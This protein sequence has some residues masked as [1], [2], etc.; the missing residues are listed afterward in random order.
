MLIMCTLSFFFCGKSYWFCPSKK[1]AFTLIEREGTRLS[2]LRTAVNESAGMQ[3][4]IECMTIHSLLTRTFSKNFL[5]FPNQTS[6]HYCLLLSEVCHFCTNVPLKQ[7]SL[8]GGHLV[9]F[10]CLHHRTIAM[11]TYIMCIIYKQFPAEWYEQS[12]KCEGIHYKN[13]FFDLWILIRWCN[14]TTVVCCNYT[15]TVTLQ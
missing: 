7:V 6:R 15:F 9:W 8:L 14:I 1:C 10:I 3:T 4:P 5:I 12:E 2:C 13:I 11:Y